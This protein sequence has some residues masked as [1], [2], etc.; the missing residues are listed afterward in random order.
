MTWKDKLIVI[1]IIIVILIFSFL[2]LF[3]K[4]K[5]DTPEDIECIIENAVLY[6]QKGCHYCLLQEEKFG[7]Q[8]EELNIIDCFET[9][10]KCR[11]NIIVTPTWVIKGEQYKGVYEIEELKEIIGCEDER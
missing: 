7:Y 10:E 4:S 8:Y 9:P 11:E 2:L 5:I 3:L 1:T 6:T